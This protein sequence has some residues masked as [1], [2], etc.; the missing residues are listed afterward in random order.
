M[1]N[2]VKNEARDAAQQIKDKT[3]ATYR[4]QKNSILTQEK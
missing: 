2:L 1:V 3:E 4:I